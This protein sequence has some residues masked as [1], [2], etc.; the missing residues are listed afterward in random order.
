MSE[1]SRGLTE[2]SQRLCQVLGL[3]QVGAGC[4]IIW[5]A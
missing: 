4:S 5:R 3:L 1:E 2:F